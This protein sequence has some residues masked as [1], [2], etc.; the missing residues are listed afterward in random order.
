[1]LG[2]GL[3]PSFTDQSNILDHRLASSMSLA[4]DWVFKHLDRFTPF[5]D[6]DTYRP[7]R[8]KRFIE[9]AIMFAVYVAVTG[10]TASPTVQSAA[11]LFQAASR[12][13]DFIDWSLR[14]PAEI[15]NYAELCA[16]V[17]ELGG[18]A[19][20]LRHRLQSAVDAG[21]LSQIERLPHRLLELGVALDWAGVEHSLPPT[22]EICTQ[23]ILGKALSAPLLDV[24]AIYA[25]THVILFGT[26]FGLMQDALPEWLRSTPVRSLLSDLLVVT[27]QAQ[28]WDLLGELLLCWDCMGFEHDLVTTAGWASFLDAFRADGAVLASTEKD[29]DGQA[30]PEAMLA[31]HV[32]E[33]SDFDRV[34]HTTLVAVLAGT[35]LLNRS[36][37]NVST[38]SISAK[39]GERLVE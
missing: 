13:A 23:T 19:G 17:D 1:M 14:F 8:M 34:Y 30:K 6:D 31:E 37:L 25:I 32:D 21:A 36:R 22:G 18:D 20:E 5:D 29:V 4:F 11:Q 27:S 7:S 10:D 15:V 39:K 35:V 38:A 12:R 16:A 2:Y 9:L 28:N 3:M 26:R 33:A 24:S